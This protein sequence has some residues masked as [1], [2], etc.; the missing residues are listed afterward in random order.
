M[1]RQGSTGPPIAGAT[2]LAG[3]R[4]RRPGHAGSCCLDELHG[5]GA[6]HG[7][8]AAAACPDVAE[9]GRALP[10]D[11]IFLGERDGYALVR[12]RARRSAPVAGADWSSCAA[13]ACC[14]RRTR[15][16]LLAYARALAHWHAAIASAAIAADP[17]C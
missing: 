6:R 3:A 4:A 11:A 10:A 9:L 16:P 15:P 12:L 17:P 13:S 1:P 14:C 7:R 8:R 2:P 5:P